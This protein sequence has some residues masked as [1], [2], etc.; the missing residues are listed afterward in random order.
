MTKKLPFLLIIFLL[1]LNLGFSQI[2]QHDFGTTSIST[3]PYTIAPGVLDTNLSNSSW[4]NSNNAWTS[5]AGAS[6]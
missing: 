5:F 3:H 1:T 2:Y 4:S 6:G